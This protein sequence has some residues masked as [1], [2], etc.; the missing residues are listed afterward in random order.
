M[1]VSKLFGKRIREVPSEANL[2]SHIFLLR[3]GYVKSVG[4]GIYSL[5]TPAVKIK[6]KIEDIVRA[7]METLGGQEV[8]L[9]VVLPGSLW[10]RSGRFESVGNELLKFK[11]RNNKNMLLAMTHEEAVVDLAE[12]FASSYSD[13]PFM[14]YQIQTKFRD[15][16]RARGGLIRLREFTMKDAYSFHL[17][18]EDL[19][20]FYKKVLLAYNRIYERVGLPEVIC[21]ESD[22]GM[23][24]GNVAHEFM[25]LCDSGEDSIVLC[26]NC[27]YKAN[28]EVAESLIPE[29]EKMIKAN[30]CN[31]EKHR[32]KVCFYKNSTKEVVVFIK[33]GLYVNESKLQKLLQSEVLFIE[34]RVFDSLDKIPENIFIDYDKKKKIIFYDVSLKN[35]VDS[36]NYFE[37]YKVEQGHFCKNCGTYLTI[38]RGIEVGNIFQ[39]GVKY[40]KSMNVTYMNKDNSNSFAIMGCYGIGITRLI[41]SLIEANHDEFGPIWPKNVCPWQV[42]ICVLNSNDDQVRAKSLKL[43]EELSSNFDVLLD[44]RNLSVGKQFADADLLGIPVRIVVSPR[45]ATEDFV[46]LKLRGEKSSNNVSICDLKNFLSKFYS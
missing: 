5:L 37:L 45:N 9:P 26:K 18:K 34:E 16:P 25:L 32:I 17:N 20:V 24:G 1:L 21:I 8:Y 41:A 27:G 36:D 22:S 6:R 13:Y 3:G 43:Y 42:H 14:I 4:S 11:D 12:H 2:I 19:E 10:K 35:I 40:T 38:S 30:P 31:M 46:E 28:L 33:F 23:M 39:L 44:D 29:T 7:E 15:E